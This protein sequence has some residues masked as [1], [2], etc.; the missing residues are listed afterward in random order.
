M[1]IPLLDKTG[2][3]ALGNRQQRRSSWPTARSNVPGHPYREPES[4]PA[5]ASPAPG[6]VARDDLVVACA[7]LVV[8]VLGVL[9]GLSTDRQVELTVGL[10]LIALGVKVAWDSR[11]AGPR[12][13]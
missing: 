2:A 13:R 10:V 11:T 9:S 3:S 8:G 1:D 12:V 4:S 7:L 6:C 5:E